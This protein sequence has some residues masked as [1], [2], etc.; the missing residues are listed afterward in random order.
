ML[1][2]VVHW[3]CH[4][5]FVCYST[6]W[7]GMC[8]KRHMNRAVWLV[9]QPGMCVPCAAMGDRE[10]QDWTFACSGSPCIL[11]RMAQPM[12][13]PVRQHLSRIPLVLWSL[14]K[15]QEIY[16]AYRSAWLR[17]LPRRML[18]MHSM[19]GLV[20]STPFIGVMDPCER[21]DAFLMGRCHNE[22]CGIVPVPSQGCHW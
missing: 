8:H 22:G 2:A 6:K 12:P 16:R 4:T 3:C 1:M 13:L 19:L 20:S 11:R 7:R 21:Y 15:I 10:R 14:A 18:Q 9:R 17:R 5:L